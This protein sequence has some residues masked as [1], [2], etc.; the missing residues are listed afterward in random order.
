MLYNLVTNGI[1]DSGFIRALT[2][3]LLSKTFCKEDKHLTS[4]WVVAFK[5]DKS[6]NAFLYKMLNSVDLC[7]EDDNEVWT[8]LQE[9]NV[10]P[11][12]GSWTVPS[13]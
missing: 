11:L 13:N 6:A 5:S 2:V 8:E 4:K 9:M 1:D 3:A 10:I 7:F 12:T